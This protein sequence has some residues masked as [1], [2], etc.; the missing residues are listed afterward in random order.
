MPPVRLLAP[1]LLLAALILVSVWFDQP[2]PRADVVYGN[3]AENFTLDPQRMS[4]QHDIRT[5]RTLFEGLVEV[6]GESGE[7]Q[8]AGA[9]GWERSADGLEWTFHL[10]PDARWSNGAPVTSRDYLYAWR[11]A[12]L[13][14]LAADYTGFFL[15]IRGAPEFFEWRTR[16]LADFLKGPGGEAAARALWKE[17]QERF[18]REV[19]LS[20][21]DDLTLVV[22]LARP[23]AYWLDL[24]A[25]PVMFPVYPPQVES[26]TRI[27]PRTAALEQDPGWTKGGVMVSNGP[28]ELVRWRPKRSMRFRR[29]PFY[30]NAAAV[31]SAT[32]ESIPFEDPNTAVLAFENGDIDW[33]T[34]TLVEYR[35]DMFEEAK[36]GTR[37]NLHVL[38]A[39]GTDYFSFNCRPRLADG[40]ANPFA[41]AAVRRAF[42]MAVDKA[43][44]VDKIT[45]LGEAVA[46]TVVPPN[47]IAGY[48][49][50]AGLPFDAAR[51]RDELAKAGWR[52]R[53]GDGLVEN[54]KGE[55]FPTVE[56]LYSAGSPRYRD[57]S[58]AL[59]A[60]W[61]AALGVQCTTRARDP[62]GY[63]DAL[64]QGDFM[65]ARGGWYG[66]YGDPTTFLGLYRT[67]D[68]NNDRKYECPEFDALLDR[69]AA[70]LDPAKRLAILTEAERMIVERDAPVIP[71]CHY[72]TVYMYDPARLTGLSRH[73][74]LEQ[75]LG[76]LQMKK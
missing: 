62:F 40:R 63:K 65:I 19:G 43:T 11:R 12:M 28:Y 71:I 56:I 36:A 59:G 20:A 58:G 74:R 10:R 51:A 5:I 70:E 32:V 33:L 68:G 4:Y 46:T 14:D 55:P 44:I 15:G 17:T 27:N 60:M 37:G 42:V 72:V 13:P 35:G 61:R 18:A 53:N 47:S 57:M 1:F 25:F 9:A 52:D 23:I 75:Y 2:E 39:F 26:F 67:G 16:A 45:R 69:A 22:R 34:D 24:C 29:N 3:T 8:P 7:P 21:P 30:W 76:R 49:S 64:K 41:D 38:D 31:P 6:D 66:D 50:P 73:P 48:Q 54:E